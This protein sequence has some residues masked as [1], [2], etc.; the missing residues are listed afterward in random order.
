[1]TIIEEYLTFSGEQMIKVLLDDG[2]CI[3]YTKERYQ[4]LEAQKL[5]NTTIVIP[6]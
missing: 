2:S 4:E 3:C 1:M 6:D 5:E